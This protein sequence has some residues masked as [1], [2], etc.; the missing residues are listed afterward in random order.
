MYNICVL[1][2]LSPSEVY[3]DCSLLHSVPPSMAVGR[4]QALWWERAMTSPPACVH[5]VKED[6]VT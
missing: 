6:T 2:S 5:G 4:D 3:W 1:V